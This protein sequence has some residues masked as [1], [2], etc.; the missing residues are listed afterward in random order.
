M[1]AAHDKP[2]KRERAWEN[3]DNYIDLSTCTYIHER[4]TT[5]GYET[6]T[7]PAWI[8]DSTLKCWDQ[9]IIPKRNEADFDELISKIEAY[10]KEN[11]FVETVVN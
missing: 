2:Y 8:I 10:A 5:T 1:E 7:E 6:L 4:R 11:G 3:G 9:K